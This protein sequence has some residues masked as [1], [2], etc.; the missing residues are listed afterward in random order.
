MN[1][2][3]AA[4]LS[5]S[6]HGLRLLSDGSSHGRCWVVENSAN[7]LSAEYTNHRAPQFFTERAIPARPL[8]SGS[9]LKSQLRLEVH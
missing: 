7:L 8:K 6:G 4:L 1:V 5:P 9:V 2:Y 3:V